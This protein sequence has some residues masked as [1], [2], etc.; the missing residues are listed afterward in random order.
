MQFHVL[1]F[2]QSGCTVIYNV[3]MHVRK[4]L[5]TTGLQRSLHVSGSLHCSSLVSSSHCMLLAVSTGYCHSLAVT[6]CLWQSLLVT[7]G[8]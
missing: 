1:I 5:V 7:A 6:A 8:L 4:Q 3:Y 2:H